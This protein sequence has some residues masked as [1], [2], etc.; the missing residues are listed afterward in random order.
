MTAESGI[1]WYVIGPSGA[2]KDSLLAYARQRLPQVAGVMFAH[3]Y[4]TRP[5]DAGGENHVALSAEE[6]AAREASGCFALCW[7]RHG[8][9]YGLGVEVA[10]WLAQGLDVVVNGS[11]S[12]LPLAAECFP[13]LRPLWITASPEVLAARLAGR[14]RESVEEIARRLVEAGSFAPPP[15]CEVLWNDGEL[16]EAGECLLTLLARQ[17][18]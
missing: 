14:G 7:R 6:F 18:V 17:P 13:T 5:A 16:A 15:A 12:M 8:L 11:R 2:G 9:A 10:M 1:L 4:I 3:R